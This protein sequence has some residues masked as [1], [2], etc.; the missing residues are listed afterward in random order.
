MIE[1]ALKNSSTNNGKALDMKLI[2][3]IDLQAGQV[4]RAVRGQRA[5]Y[6]PVR[7]ALAGGSDPRQL[8][9]ALVDACQADIVYVADLDA[10]QHRPAQTDALRVLLDSVPACQVWLDAGFADAAAV[11]HLLEQLGPAGARVAPVFGSESLRSRTAARDALRDRQRA[12]LSLDR[13]ADRPLDPT[14][15]WQEPAHWPQRVIMMALERVGAEVGPDLRLL[16]DLQRQAPADCRLIGA[17]GLRHRRD[18]DAARVAGAAGWLVASALHDG[19]LGRHA[20]AAVPALHSAAAATPGY[21]DA[22]S[23]TPPVTQCRAV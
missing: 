4:V 2:P 1:P 20:P 8:A 9:P 5:L 13:L 19:R 23:A 11:C 17:G 15:C 21:S 12:I 18:Q 10:L 3:V 22:R 16:R 6:Q 14:G 7:S